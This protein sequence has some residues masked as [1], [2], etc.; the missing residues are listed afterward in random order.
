MLAV[1]IHRRSQ[2]PLF[3]RRIKSR[4]D[5]GYV[6]VSLLSLYRRFRQGDYVRLHWRQFVS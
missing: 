2:R 6:C 5:D 1:S 3:R 4:M